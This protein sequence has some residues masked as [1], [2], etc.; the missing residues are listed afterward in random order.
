MLRFTLAAVVAVVMIASSADAIKCYFGTPSLATMTS[1]TCPSG[2][3][4]MAVG[5]TTNGAS[6]GIASCSNSMSSCDTETETGSVK[7]K[8]CC[9]SGDD[10]NDKALWRLV[11]LRSLTQP[12]WFSLWAWPGWWKCLLTEECKHAC[13]NSRNIG[14]PT[15]FGFWASR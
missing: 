9:C 14:L 6:V 11:A 4:C 3:K 13:E 2:D 12:A 8:T 15:I 10:C 1:M 5:T 7:V